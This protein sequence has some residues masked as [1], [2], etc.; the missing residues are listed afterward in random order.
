[1]P[2]RGTQVL[3]ALF[4]A[5]FAGSAWLAVQLLRSRCEG[6]SCTYVGIAW[7]FW[8]GLCFLPTGLLG[9][10]L[11]RARSLPPGWRRVLRAL[12]AL[13]GLAGA[14]LGLAWLSGYLRN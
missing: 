8:L 5:A 9:L 2:A 3:A 4:V 11:A 10:G 6:F 13:Q 1:M 12:L 14:L 7:L